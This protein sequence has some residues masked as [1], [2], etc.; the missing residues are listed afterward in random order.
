MCEYTK[1][2]MQYPLTRYGHSCLSCSGPAVQ[3]SK[4]LVVKGHRFLKNGRLHLYGAHSCVFFVIVWSR[5]LVLNG[6]LLRH[7]YYECSH[8]LRSISFCLCHLSFKMTSLSSCH[9]CHRS[10]CCLDALA[11]LHGNKLEVEVN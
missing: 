9:S 4:Q 6:I 1:L 5:N 8:C 10:C 7:S 3:K 2:L 11:E